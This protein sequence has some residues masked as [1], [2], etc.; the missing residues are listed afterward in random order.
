[1]HIED[2]LSHLKDTYKS[3]QVSIA[4]VYYEDKWV[5]LFT[6]VSF[7]YE[8]ADHVNKTLSQ[9]EQL[10][11][12]SKGQRFRIYKKSFPYEELDLLCD[13]FSE[14]ML[15]TSD[16]GI[17]YDPIDI[18]N[19]DISFSHQYSLDGVH[20]E[21]SVYRSRKSN[22]RFYS[23]QFIDSLKSDVIEHGY[24]D[25]HEAI[26]FLIDKEH[27]V[28]NST[29]FVIRAPLFSKIEKVSLDDDGIKI[30]VRHHKN[31]SGLILQY[32]KYHSSNN[33]SQ[34][35]S[36]SE[37]GTEPY[38]QT[39]GT[40]TDDG[41]FIKWQ[42]DMEKIDLSQ[43]SYENDAREIILFF[44]PLG[45]KISGV[46][47]SLDD[48]IAEK[49]LLANNPLAKVFEKFC[50]LENFEKI[51]TNPENVKKD[52]FRLGI[53]DNFE[54]AVYW[55]FTVC[56]F[57]TIWFGKDFEE[58]RDGQR[59]V[60]GSADLLCYNEQEKSMVLV[61]CKTSNPNDTHIDSIKNL[62]D[63]LGEE[64]KKLG[65]K[66]VPIIASSKPADA[67]RTKC[68][69]AGVRLIDENDMKKII[70]EIDKK[71]KPGLLLNTE[72]APLD[73]ALSSFGT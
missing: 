22:H 19:S 18:K 23:G 11:Q 57:Q 28:N 43:Q 37:I 67:I 52:G 58:L 21:Y 45:L 54:R 38:D 59:R 72:T 53:S 5:N 14:G 1:M 60:E 17:D 32:K 3:I 63:R 49:Y 46:T 70:G 6:S 55:M 56:G 24:E 40:T 7:A 4:C 9:N 64:M 29:D 51:L 16:V 34:Y 31:L 73:S 10:S 36:E 47:K 44:K 48:I 35:N 41:D 20:G 33:I 61:S 30:V 42:I 15:E 50:S 2:V 62:A 25:I 39:K 65:L 26:R 68:I 13:S 12:L 27:S 8:D 71:P 69:N 66:M